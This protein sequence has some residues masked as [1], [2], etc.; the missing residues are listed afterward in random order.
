MSGSFLDARP[1]LRVTLLLA[2]WLACSAAAYSRLQ[3]ARYEFSDRASTKR[4]LRRNDGN[5]GHATIDFGGQWMMGRM[6]VVGRGRELYHRQAQWPTAWA[7]YPTADE[8]VLRRELSFPASRRPAAFSGESSM[9]DAEAM[10]FWFM[11][12][13]ADGW[14]DATNSVALPTAA[15]EPWAAL[16]LNV[17]AQSLLT[18][19][20]IKA[21]NR[22]AIG[23]PLYPPI[24]AMLMAPLAATNDPRSA[25]AVMQYGTILLTF[26]AG[27]LIAGISCGRVWWPVAVL[28]ILTF[29]GYLSG[30]DLGQNQVVSLT[31]LVA[32]WRLTQVGRPWLG[33][34]VWG[35]LAFKP[36][37]AASFLMVPLVLGQWRMVVAMCLTAALW[38]LASLPLVG[39]QSW[40]DWLAVGREASAL[41]EVNEKWIGL[42]RD[43]A[44]LIRRPLLDFQ[45]SAEERSSPLLNRLCL[46]PYVLI[47][48]TT[49]LVLWTT[50]K[51]SGL[52]GLR[53]GFPA[54]AAYLCCWHFMYYDA[55]LALFPI[56]VLSAD[57][58]ALW[59]GVWTV[60]GESGPP[61]RLSMPGMLAAA[62][63]GLYAVEN[64]LMYLALAG[65][66]EFGRFGG[67]SAVIGGMPSKP[68]KLS[69]DTTIFTACDTV[70][71]LLLWALLVIRL[72][73]AGRN[74]AEPIQR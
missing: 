44:G 36:V 24:H 14:D 46:L 37:W 18:E 56:A 60:Q 47:A 63:F 10:L 3:H 35:L 48:G 51:K 1:R 65:T 40:F 33:G 31:L 32:G 2:A 16:T 53:A 19:G 72:G 57:P 11:G 74:A 5:Y 6:L 7:A 17:A 52:V 68:P 13:D 58:R 42:S 43:L 69:A 71:L 23:G 9:H 8:S 25:Y 49:L 15:G 50:R 34:I 30:L 38:I 22:P 29:P 4:E 41:Y 73:F 62:L 26:A 45:A 39:V 20:R 67:P 66:I 59:G 70:I 64:F 54:L 27:F 12:R 28:G 61:R 55:V 21:L